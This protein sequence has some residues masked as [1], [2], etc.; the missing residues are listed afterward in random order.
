MD[1]RKLRGFLTDVED[2]IFIEDEMREAD[3]IFLPGNR[4]PDMAEEAAALYGQGLAPVVIPSGRWYI[5]GERFE[6]PLKK[7]EIYDERY[8]TECDFLRDVLMKNGV[9]D[10]AILCEREASFTYQNAINTRKLTDARGM[11]FRRAILCA[12]TIHARRAG[13]YYRLLYPETEILIRPVPAQGITRENWLSRGDY[14]EAV[15]SEF[16]RIGGQFLKITR[17][18][19]DDGDGD[20]LL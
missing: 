18:L 19:S 14:A 1:R 7:G 5:G 4:Y 2:F 16:G 12:N 11:T 8:E 9:P 6:G 10:E 13:M 20:Y 17:A 15:L 3:V